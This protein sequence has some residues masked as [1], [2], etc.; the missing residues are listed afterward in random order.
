MST[1][2]EG[3][4]APAVLHGV[5]L[6]TKLG[7]CLVDCAVGK[8]VQRPMRTAQLCQLLATMQ[9]L[10][11]SPASA[12][13]ELAGLGPG[14]G[15]VLLEAQRVIVAVLCDPQ[16]GKSAARLAGKQ[17]L[18]SF[19]RHF[20][21]QVRALEAAQE[22]E[23][24]E[25]LGKYTYSSATLELQE[26]GTL[27]VFANFVQAFAQPV[28]L[29]PT[30]VPAVLRPLLE[31]PDALR[32]MLIDPGAAAAD[33]VM[34][35]T[36]P[37]VQRLLVHSAGE[38]V[39]VLWRIVRAH[40]SALCSH[41]ASAT[42]KQNLK[43]RTATLAFPSLRDADGSCL[44]VALRQVRLPPGGGCLLLF[45]E[46]GFEAAATQAAA[47]ESVTASE[48]VAPQAVRAALK[49][50]A[51]TVNGCFPSSTHSANDQANDQGK[52][53]AEREARPN[54]SRVGAAAAPEERQSVQR[55]PPGALP[56][57]QK[58]AQDLNAATPILPPLASA[59]ERSRRDGAPMLSPLQ[60]EVPSPRLS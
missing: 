36:E 44:H 35:A 38:H 37:C 31:L 56:P 40:A 4:S 47:T 39:P 22:R 60:L 30:L 14:T 17:I 5:V 51:R 33:Q 45:F 13:V 58:P 52:E 15:V 59:V 55:L 28:L 26:H 42:D 18:S 11:G 12:Y 41:R 25:A 29:K 10:S 1:V 2:S 24:Q 8:Y 27:P 20:G 34:L 46:A 3:G 50:V 57:L 23:L 21:Q 16:Q 48:A 6:L 54:E 32:A 49:H 19:C 7:K 43:Q 9:D 53:E